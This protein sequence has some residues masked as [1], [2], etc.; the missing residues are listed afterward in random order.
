MGPR[1][2]ALA[3][4]LKHRLGIPYRKITELFKVAFGLEVS[5]GRLCQANERLAERATPVYEELVEAIRRC[6]AVNTDE[7][8][9]RIGVLSA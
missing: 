9:W 2:K 5:P 8:G 3:A 4:D 1:A 7:T 6:A